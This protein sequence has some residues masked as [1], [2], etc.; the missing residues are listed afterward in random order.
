VVCSASRGSSHSRRS[1]TADRA[2]I[3]SRI[4]GT[5]A[6]PTRLRSTGVTS[7]NARWPASANT[8][9]LAIGSLTAEPNTSS[10]AQDAIESGLGQPQLSSA[11]HRPLDVLRRTVMRL[12]V[13]P[14]RREIT[15]L[16]IAQA[17]L[18]GVRWPREL[19]SAA[20]GQ[21]ADD[22]PL[23]A[24]PAF[25]NCASGVDD[26]VVRVDCAGYHRLA[27]ARASVDDSV[28]AVA[29][30]RVG[31]EEHPSDLGVDHLLDDHREPHGG[32]VDAVGHPVTDRPIGP[33][34]R[35]ASACRVEHGVRADDVEVGVLLASEPCPG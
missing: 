19:L 17:R 14:Q 4:R 16:S 22:H 6:R 24:Q 25:Q 11:V 28:P 33:Q 15:D 1:T 18:L 2:S 13:P 35:P 30:H 9:G 7:T 34:L 8:A 29:G 26:E 31:G 32:V 3:T 10:D 23:V 5:N 12:D 20:A 27:Q 21:C